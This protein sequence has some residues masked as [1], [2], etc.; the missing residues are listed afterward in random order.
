[1]QKAV[2]G[3]RGVLLQLHLTRRVQEGQTDGSLTFQLHQAGGVIRNG[4]HI[5]HNAPCT[6][7][8]DAIRS[9]GGKRFT[10]SL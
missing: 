7:K 4:T 10:R 3:A 2:T 9:A 1:M 6:K 8:I 5:I